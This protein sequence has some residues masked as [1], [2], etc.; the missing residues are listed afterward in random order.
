[1]AA[2]VVA[3]LVE[4]FWNGHPYPVAAPAATACRL[5]GRTQAVYDAV[6]LPHA[7]LA[8]YCNGLDADVDAGPQ[9]ARPARGMTMPG[10]GVRC[11]AAN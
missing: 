9:G 1:M 2:V 10:A 8:D 6:D 11:S 3:Q 7:E 5:D 4:R